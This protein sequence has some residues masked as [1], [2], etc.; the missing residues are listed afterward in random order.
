MDQLPSLRF[1]LGLVFLLSAVLAHI[2]LS[3]DIRSVRTGS[4]QWSPRYWWYTVGGAGVLLGGLFV[5]DVSVPGGVVGAVVLSL[6]LGVIPSIPVYLGR[7]YL[8]SHPTD[9]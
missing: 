9:R 1:L 2:G 4:Q 6:I 8:A 3:T 5:L 7:R